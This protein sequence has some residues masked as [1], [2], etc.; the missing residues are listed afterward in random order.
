MNDHELDEM[1]NRW[2][3]PPVRTELQERVEAGHVAGPKRRYF[4][5]VGW[6]GLFAG[7]AAAAVLFL[8]VCTEAFPD[9]LGSPSPALRP[10]YVAMSNVTAYAKDG[11]SRP[12]STVYSSSYKGTEIVLMEDDP[13]DP[14]HQAIMNIHLSVHRIML[15]FVPNLVMPESAAKDAWFS[16]YVKSGCVDKGDVVIGHETLLAHQ[17]TVIQNVGEGWR[18]TAWRSPDLG[19]FPLRT[20]N[21]EP[22]SGGIYRLT[23]QRDTVSVMTRRSDGRGW[24][25]AQ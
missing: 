22:V 5:S 3:V 9:V 21:E 20:R 23:E 10:P 6:K 2:G 15:Q 16:A 14:I 25:L 12:E 11:S 1:L 13:G 4:P 19:C 24:Q 7:V 8:V 18:W 17:T